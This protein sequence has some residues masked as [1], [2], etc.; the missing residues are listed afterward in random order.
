[1]AMVNMA[2]AD[3][4]ATEYK[5]SPYGY[6]LCISLTEEQVEALGLD[7]NPPAAGS[8]VGIQAIAIVKRVTQES[9][10]G[11]PE[12][13]G[14]DS[15]IDVCLTFQITDMEVTGASSQGGK[16]ASMLYGGDAD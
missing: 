16:A 14:E 5:P 15:S 9:E 3:D 1:M 11:D 7:K 8:K 2:I 6:G 4:E 10:A 13:A 12:E